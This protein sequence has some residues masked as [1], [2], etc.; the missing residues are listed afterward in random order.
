M[1]IFAPTVP[2]ARALLTDLYQLTMAYAYWKSGKAEQEAVFHL[3]FRKQP[4]QGGFTVASGLADSIEYLRGFKFE[5]SDL[6]YLGRLTGNDGKRLFLE[7]YVPPGKDGFGARFI[8]LRELDGKPF[9]T[10]DTGEVR[11]YAEYSN[12]IK[13]NRRF[14]T[15]DMIYKGELEY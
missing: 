2:R 14:K 15:A 9:L 7:E 5:K 8:F 12:G 11:F 3:L 4:F 6:D 13:V 1:K 10:K